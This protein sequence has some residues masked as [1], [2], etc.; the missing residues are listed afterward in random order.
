MTLLEQKRAMAQR[1]YQEEQKYWKDNE[2]QFTKCVYIFH[3]TPASHRSPRS[4]QSLN[5]EEACLELIPL[6]LG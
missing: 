6:R 5:Q 1:Q 3:F 4:S 2:E